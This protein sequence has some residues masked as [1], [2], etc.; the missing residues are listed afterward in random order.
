MNFQ[1]N[2]NPLFFYSKKN[3]M[4]TAKNMSLLSGTLL[5]FLNWQDSIQVLGQ[6]STLF[7]FPVLLLQWSAT[8]MSV[9][10]NFYIWMWKQG[11][12]RG[13]WR[14]LQAGWGLQSG[15]VAGFPRRSAPPGP[16]QRCSTAA[17][18]VSTTHS[19]GAGA[20]CQRAILSST[21]NYFPWNNSYS[22]KM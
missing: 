22:F 8:A 12:S 5:V 15:A 18:A 3:A 11:A 2:W 4:L 20:E 19:S 7:Y 6:V 13:L 9:S 10:V 17:G 21:A 16:G 14:S 1:G